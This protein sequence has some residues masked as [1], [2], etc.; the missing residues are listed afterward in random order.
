MGVV[1][2]A[3]NPYLDRLVAVKYLKGKKYDQK[4]LHR[5]MQEGKLLGKLIHPNLVSVLDFGGNEQ[6]EPYMVME[7]LEGESLADLIHRTGTIAL[8]LALEI[9]IQTCDGLA[10]AHKAGAVHRDIKPS[11]I[12][13]MEKSGGKPVVKLL[14]FGIAKLCFPED[15]AAAADL[16]RTGEIFGSPLYM[17]PEQALGKTVDERSDLYSLGCVL[18]EMLTGRPPVMGK[19]AME[20][21]FKHVTD[22][23]LPLNKAVSNKNYPAST[24]ALI[25][26]LL[27]K[28]PGD[29]FE[30]AEELASMVRGLVSDNGSDSQKLNERARKLAMRTA[31]EGASLVSERPVNG[32]GWSPKQGII[33]LVAQVVILCAAATWFAS[34]YK[35]PPSLVSPPGKSLP[36]KPLSAAHPPETTNVEPIGNVI[37]D[38]YKPGEIDRTFLAR[39][40]EKGGDT[41]ELGDKELG[42]ADFK[43][44]AEQGQ[45]LSQITF[46]RSTG[47]T[48]EDI[49]LLQKLPLAKLNIDECDINESGLIA[50]SKLPALRQLT[51]RNC[52][53]LNPKAF[54]VL[55]YMTELTD[56]FIDGCLLDPL[57]LKRALPL[58]D[59]HTLRIAGS[60]TVGRSSQ[61]KMLRCNAA[62]PAIAE[63]KALGNLNLTATDVT[64]DGIAALVSLDRLTDLDLSKCERV[65]DEAVGSLIRIPHLRYLR[66]RDTSFTLAGVERLLRAGKLQAVVVSNRIGKL[67]PYL[68]DQAARHHLNF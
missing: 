24:Q 45:K 46:K 63:C 47:L 37:D 68:E 10:E 12:F 32:V 57:V 13:V 27:A 28:E 48:S 39:E 3:H 26:C 59:L 20:T 44:L 19:T 62:L 30:S 8:P 25:D 43:I 23:P 54:F 9:V 18:Y 61:F 56:L 66:I 6:G 42:P 2:K 58:R 36:E 41:I 5:F 1:F 14:D 53:E 21:I 65:G 33:M 55:K 22:R 67:S 15:P 17:S 52:S 49:L 31:R 11:N 51:L 64:S 35:F 38:V 50:I 40:L 60:A 29:R 7:Y 16:T 4:E 34:T